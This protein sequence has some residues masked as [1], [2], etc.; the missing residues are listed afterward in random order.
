MTAYEWPAGRAGDHDDRQGRRAHRAALGLGGHRGGELRAP[1]AP[2]RAGPA[3]AAAP[4]GATELW[5]P[6]GPTS[7]LRGQPAD[8]GRVSGRVVDIAFEPTTGRR[9]YAASASG[10]VWFT[11]DAGSSWRS[12]GGWM[13]GPTTA[14][15]FLVNPL[16]CGALLVEFPNAGNAGQ[17]VVWVGTGE[18]E[19]LVTTTGEP[20][21]RLP[22]IGVLRGLGPALK[23]ATDNTAFVLE[24]T[25]LSGTACFRMAHAPGGSVVVATGIGLSSGP[26]APGP[27]NLESGR[28]TSDD[29]TGGAGDSGA[30]AV[31][32][33]RRHAGDRGDH[34]RPPVGVFLDDSNTVEVH[35]RDAGS[36]TF[37]AGRAA[38]RSD[39]V[40][41]T[42]T[43]RAAI[44]AGRDGRIVWVLGRTAVFRIDATAANPVG[45]RIRD[46]P[47]IWAAAAASTEIAIAVDPPTPPGWP[48]AGPSSRARPMP[49]GCTSA[50]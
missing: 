30:D 22:G 7:S 40:P 32:R 37:T 13:P 33:R 34:P 44:A 9:G 25:N 42:P 39:R 8:D 31:H 27:R 1:S 47:P 6:I 36:P 19:G 43:G 49:L 11:D 24:A 3:P 17:D 28:R 14:G 38:R 23:P 16:S 2:A 12:L 5:A 18:P 20:G 45:L 10:G 15:S 21:G 46:T 50:R 29:G 26:P 4:S 41:M 48:L 35:F